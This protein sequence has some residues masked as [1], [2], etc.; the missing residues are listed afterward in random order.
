MPTISAC[1]LEF[2]VDDETKLIG[3]IAAY[4][5]ISEYELFRIAHKNWFNRPITENRLDVI[6]KEYLACGE[7]PFWVNDFARKAQE[8]LKTG[9]L[10]YKDYG[11]ERRAC[12]RRSKIKGWLI[13]FLL[14][15][16]LLLYSIL[17]TGYPSY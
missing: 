3:F 13:T 7:A 9:K 16:F 11:I 6:F 2:L 8:R 15:V 5:Q 14:Y 12:D 1:R 17:I 10:N 4:L